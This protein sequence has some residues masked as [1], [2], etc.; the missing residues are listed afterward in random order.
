MAQRVHHGMWFGGSVLP[1]TR[2]GW[3][4][5]G[6]AAAW[7]VLTAGWRLMG[8]AGAVPG[9]ACGAAGGVVALVALLRFGERAVAVFAALFPLAF[10]VLFVVA[11][12]IF[13]H[14]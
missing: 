1:T 12:L 7:L 10:V 5:V 6:L 14:S 8:S 11:E 3:V 13:G 4:A 2:V 9:F